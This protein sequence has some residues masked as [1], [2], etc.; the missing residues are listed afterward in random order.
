LGTV[1]TCYFLYKFKRNVWREKQAEGA[2]ITDAAY[3]KACGLLTYTAIDL[4]KWRFAIS[5][6]SLGIPLFCE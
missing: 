4:S 3:R 1:E 6:T 5:I 2:S